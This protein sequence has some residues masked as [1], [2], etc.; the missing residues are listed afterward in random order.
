MLVSVQD[1]KWNRFPM[2]FG[3]TVHRSCLAQVDS[4]RRDKRRWAIL[5]LDENGR[6]QRCNAP[7][8]YSGDTYHISRTDGQDT[9]PLGP[10]RLNLPANKT[11]RHEFNLN[12][13]DR[14]IRVIRGKPIASF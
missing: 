12:G 2:L 5:G 11:N 1:V 9:Q 8:F 6:A 4:I 3:G 10:S 14:A 7:E 13:I